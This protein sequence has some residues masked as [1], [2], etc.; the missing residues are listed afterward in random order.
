MKPLI[1]ID[2]FDAGIYQD[3]TIPITNGGQMFYGCDIH[4]DNSI[5]EITQ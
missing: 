3:A 4:R 2:Q 5:I 1:V